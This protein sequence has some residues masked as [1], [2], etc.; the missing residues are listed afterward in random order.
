MSLKDFSTEKRHQLDK[1]WLPAE[2]MFQSAFVCALLDLE[3]HAEQRIESPPALTEAINSIQ[4]ARGMCPFG[5]WE[6]FVHLR[7]TPFRK[8][9]W[10]A[11]R[12]WRLVHEHSADVLE[13]R[14]FDCVFYDEYSLLEELGS[15]RVWWRVCEEVTK[16]VAR[17]IPLI[18]P[19]T[20]AWPSN[21]QIYE[22]VRRVA[23]ERDYLDFEPDVEA[24]SRVYQFGKL[25]SR[26]TSS[27]L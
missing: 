19:P 11:L 22:T 26:G 14:N 2:C 18:A 12:L 9:T 16:A 8:P 23:V 7:R 13:S 6:P 24:V 15:R 4:K 27:A 25:G 3:A 17:S 1:I 5:D 21:E 10:S 20:W